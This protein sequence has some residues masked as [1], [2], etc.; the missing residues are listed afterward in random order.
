MLE[1]PIGTNTALIEGSG[2]AL[3]RKTYGHI[4]L[5]PVS[6]VLPDSE[7]RRRAVQNQT[8]P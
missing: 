8:V 1:N 3:D 2:G 6:E 7:T 4:L 5:E